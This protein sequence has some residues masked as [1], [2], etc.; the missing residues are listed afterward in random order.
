MGV[1]GIDGRWPAPLGGAGYVPGWGGCMY[2]CGAVGD[3]AISKTLAAREGWGHLR[4]ICP[5]GAYMAVSKIIL[6]NYDESSDQNTYVDRWAY[7]SQAGS[8]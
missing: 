5:I 4:G 2:A 6:A 8:P 3:G 7:A 1:G